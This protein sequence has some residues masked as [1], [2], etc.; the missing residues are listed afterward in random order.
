LDSDPEDAG[1]FTRAV[2]SEKKDPTMALLGLVASSFRIAFH[3]P[4]YLFA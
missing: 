4:G 1:G 2:S 3:A